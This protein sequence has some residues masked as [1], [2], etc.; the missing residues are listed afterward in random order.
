[1][2]KIAY[3]S[4]LAPQRSGIADYSQALLPHFFDTTE[5]HLWVSGFTPT[6]SRL[7]QECEII[8]YEQAPTRLRELDQYDGIIYQQG[9][10]I[11]YHRQIYETA[12]LYP[13]VNVLHDLS[14]HPFLATYWLEYKKDG[15]GYLEEMRYAHGD[16]GLKV[17]QAGLTA[18]Q[19]GRFDHTPWHTTPL[20]YP[21]NRR[22][23]RR[24][25]GMIV[26]S[27]F[28]RQHVEEN[29]PELPITTIAQLPPDETFSGETP[30]SIED[31]RR[32]RGLIL[33][34]LGFFT[35]AK[36]LDVALKAF[37]NL[38]KHGVEAVYLL[39]GEIQSSFPLARMVSD[40]GLTLGEEVLTTGFV[41]DVALL[42]IYLELADICISLR[43]QTMGETS[44]I[45]VRALALGTPV[46]VSD[47]G[48]FGDLPNDCVVKISPGAGE[49]D[50][51]T[52]YLLELER[53]PSL[54]KFLGEQAQR[55]IAQHG[56]AERTV[57]QYLHFCQETREHAPLDPYPPEYLV[58][59]TADEKKTA[60]AQEGDPLNSIVLRVEHD[61]STE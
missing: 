10:E 14:L 7:Q 6:D 12:L 19:A 3:F 51:L 58:S 39:V 56:E 61:L 20:R 40:L 23:L 53:S 41:E 57:A 59:R 16:A 38:R 44:A 9:N 52:R 4:P 11:H 2:L 55:Y 50:R 28:S 22:L 18:F 24:S 8:D 13:G 30:A 32:Y 29:E 21:L 33:I 43:P 5:I 35:T 1:M 45:A 48:W 27:A 46:I 36:G 47:V 15:Q 54:R 17:A 60:A 31:L 26:H 42:N 34:S 49:I 25:K 37:A